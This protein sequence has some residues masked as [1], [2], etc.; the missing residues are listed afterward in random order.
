M[1]ILILLI[2]AILSVSCSSKKAN[3][4]YV[5]GT[6]YDLNKEL[7]KVLKSEKDPKKQI[8]K[9]KQLIEAENDRT[10]TVILGKQQEYKKVRDQEIHDLIKKP[11]TPI[12]APDKVLR[13]FFFPWIDSKGILHSK[14]YEFAVADKGRWV[15]G[16][17]LLDGKGSIKLLSPL[18]K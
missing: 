11:V 13:V 15:L 10:A 14:S 4:T 3:I 9:L 12:K 6:K 18:D 2:I 16:N 8:E 1:K 5:N 7:N 17:Y